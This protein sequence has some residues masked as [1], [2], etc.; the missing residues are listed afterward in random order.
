M[1]PVANP[2]NPWHRTHIEWEGDEAPPDASLEVFEE[3]AK[4]I[5]SENDSPDVPHR[6]SVN[7]YRGCMHAC[8]YCYARPSHQHLGFGAGTDFDRKI[9]AK[10]NA[11]TLLRA[12]FEKRSWTGERVTFSGNTDCYQPL[13]GT[14]RLTRAC[15]EVCA[16]FRN[17]VAI[18]TK[19]SLVRR[20]LDVLSRLAADGCA[21]VLVS[22]PFADDAVRKKVEPWA[23]TVEQRF[24]TLRALSDAGVPT[25]VMVAPIIPA[26]NDGDVAAVLERAHEAGARRA[27]MQLLRLPAEVMEVF[28][29]RMEEAF[30]ARQKRMESALVQV[31]L[32]RRNSSEFGD[33]MRGHGPRWEI[34]RQLFART[35]ERLGMNRDALPTPKPF[36]R[37]TAQRG[38]FDE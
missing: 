11:P 8:A 16:D 38:L 35:V 33:R 17:P 7:P 26:L 36:R 28:D 1:R 2:P 37:V 6:W 29:A 15:L 5:L 10:V 27:A 30:P 18:I 32:G 13:E 3:R 24:A 12:A 19:G 20:D 14:Y 9:V 31:R 25:G 22:I 21:L 4:S 23:A 34:V